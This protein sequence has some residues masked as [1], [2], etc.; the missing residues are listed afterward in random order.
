M[1]LAAWYGPG[2]MRTG[3]VGGLA[4]LFAEIADAAIAEAQANRLPEYELEKAEEL[5]ALGIAMCE[6][7]EKHYG[8]DESVFVIRA[9][10]PL[11]FSFSDESGRIVAVHRLKPDLVYRSEHDGGIWLGEHKTAKQIRTGHLTIDGQARP[12]GVMAEPA[13]RKAGIITANAPFKGIM[14]NFLRKALSD[15]RPKNEEGKSLNKDGSVSKSQPAPVF[16]RHPV[17]LSRKAKVQ[18]LKRIR[19]E[20]VFITRYAQD[21]RNRTVDPA[22]IFK[23]AHSSCEKFCQFFPICTAEE[24]GADIN[25]MTRS[26]YVV[27]DPY[28]YDEDTTD[29]RSS[30]EMG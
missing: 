20:T 26:L 30:F 16:K 4:E 2:L 22:G 28:L 3:G 19:N 11:E 21:I 29:E 7:Y 27:R 24:D 18:T 9:E 1:A 15:E 6:A 12:Y 25:E 8:L 14:Y 17:V 10:V 5:A 23:T 13:L